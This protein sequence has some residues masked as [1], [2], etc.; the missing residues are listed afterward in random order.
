MIDE[1][2]NVAIHFSDPLFVPEGWQGINFGTSLRLSLTAMDGSEV[3]GMYR[4]P[5]L[6]NDE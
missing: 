5:P 3:L 6:E 2:G 1:V 4:P